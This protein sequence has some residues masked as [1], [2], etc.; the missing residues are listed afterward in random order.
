MEANPPNENNS[1][2][3]AVVASTYWDMR[4][5]VACAATDAEFQNRL[6]A[7]DQTLNLPIIER[8]PNPDPNRVPYSAQQQRAGPRVAA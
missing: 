4:L 6:M 2:R 5:S 1:T 7:R 3:R 8:Q